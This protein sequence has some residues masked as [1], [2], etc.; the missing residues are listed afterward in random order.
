[1]GSFL[2]AAALLLLLGA[3]DPNPRYWR[4]EAG[5]KELCAMTGYGCAPPNAT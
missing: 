3:A 2:L 5:L 1:M 4:S